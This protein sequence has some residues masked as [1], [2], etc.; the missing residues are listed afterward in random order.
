MTNQTVT[1]L[2][3]KF[4]V[5]FYLFGMSDWDASCWKSLV[6]KNLGESKRV[7]IPGTQNNFY[8]VDSLTEEGKAL[9]RSIVVDRLAQ[10]ENS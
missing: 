3:E 8:L 1:L 6:S 5:T 2:E 9:A 10:Q 4:L 7:D